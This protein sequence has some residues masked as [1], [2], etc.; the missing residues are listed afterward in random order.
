[1]FDARIDA[2][3]IACMGRWAPGSA[4]LRL[5]RTITPEAIAAW[6]RRCA[7]PSLPAAPLDFLSLPAIASEAARSLP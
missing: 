5:Y 6:A 2:R 3:D 1:M 7:A 4:C